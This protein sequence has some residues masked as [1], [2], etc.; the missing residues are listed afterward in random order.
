MLNQTDWWK[1]LLIVLVLAVGSFY[2]LP[3]LFG[4]DPGVQVRGARGQSVTAATLEQVESVLADAAIETKAIARE[5][6]GIK[7][8]FADSERQLQARDAIES[9]L[10]NTYTT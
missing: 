3:N 4:N 8:R 7:I 2:A 9:A 6:D 10:G 1:Y 5:S